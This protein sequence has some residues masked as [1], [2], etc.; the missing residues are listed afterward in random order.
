MLL[1]LSRGSFLA[2][3]SVV[4]HDRDEALE[5]EAKLLLGHSLA[6]RQRGEG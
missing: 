5:Y 4:G 2:L 3:A 1:W 6:D